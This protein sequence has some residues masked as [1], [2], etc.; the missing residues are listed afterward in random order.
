MFDDIGNVIMWRVPGHEIKWKGLCDKNID[1]LHASKQFMKKK[2]CY[3]TKIMLSG[4]C[5]WKSI[6]KILDGAREGVVRK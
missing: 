5:V 6:G 3:K 4:I 2:V 1:K